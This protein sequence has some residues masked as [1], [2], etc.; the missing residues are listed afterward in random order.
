MKSWPELF[1]RQNLA[2]S[3]PTVSIL[4]IRPLSR[5]VCQEYYSVDLTASQQQ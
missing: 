2:G 5:D 4:K 3:R 1:V